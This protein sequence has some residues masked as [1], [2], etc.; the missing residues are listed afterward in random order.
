MKLYN[1]P[2]NITTLKTFKDSN[3]NQYELRG[4]QGILSSNGC[5]KTNYYELHKKDKKSKD[6]QKCE[7]KEEMYKDSF[8]GF[9]PYEI[10]KERLDKVT[11]KSIENSN[12]VKNLN[13]YDIELKN[14]VL[15]MNEPLRVLYTTDSNGKPLS[16]IK[17]PENMT[18]N[19]SP[20][21][22]NM[23]KRFLKLLSLV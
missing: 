13:G 14:D 15:T 8:Y 4:E 11:G 12:I 5:Y 16:K 21:L 2:T 6:F 18:I 1:Q 3:G 19:N 17:L 9:E 23:T 10:K 22:S 7:V 20:K